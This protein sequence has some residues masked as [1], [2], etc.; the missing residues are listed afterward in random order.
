MVK[1]AL[2]G[3]RHKRASPNVGAGLGEFCTL[4]LAPTEDCFQVADGALSSSFSRPAPRFDRFN[5][6]KDH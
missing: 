2:Q 4:V 5:P 1:S 3:F 6:L